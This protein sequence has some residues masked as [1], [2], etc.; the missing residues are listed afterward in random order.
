M[1]S[2]KLVAYFSCSGVTR[3]V[4]Q[5]LADAVGGDLYEITPAQPYTNADLNWMDKSSRSTV[6]MKDPNSRPA[7]AGKVERLKHCSLSTI[8]KKDA[9]NQAP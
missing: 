5:T 4:A 8:P 1:S 2:K 3:S 6:E 9:Q 7:I